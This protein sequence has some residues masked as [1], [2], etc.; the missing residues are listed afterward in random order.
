M[1]KSEKGVVYITLYMDDI[2]LIGNPEAVE[3]AIGLLWRIVWFWKL[4]KNYM[5]I[6]HV[7]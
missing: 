6:C 4:R 2:L 3:E 5:T 1:K 7:E